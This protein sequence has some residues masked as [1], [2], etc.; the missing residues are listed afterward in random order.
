MNEKNRNAVKTFAIIGSILVYAAFVIYSEYHFYNL[1]TA[2][3]PPGPAQLVG[4]L[5]V[6]V[7]GM[8][9]VFLPRVFTT[10]RKAI[11]KPQP[12]HEKLP[13]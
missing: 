6:A 5:A 12:G 7:T 13:G 2:F 4:Y 9:A 8:T 11:V 1:V 10:C 3:L